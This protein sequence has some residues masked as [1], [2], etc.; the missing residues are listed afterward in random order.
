MKRL[1][2]GSML[3]AGAA[4]VLVSVTAW[5]RPDSEQD[6]AAQ[7][8]R[9]RLLVIQS[10]CGGC[11]G[12]GSDPSV[13]G[14]LA[15]PQ[16]SAGDTKIGPCAL[17]P[18][19]KPCF[20]TRPK[21]L[22]PH[23]VTGTGRYSE[24]QIFNALRYG[25][26]PD[27]TPDVEITGTTPG[28]GNYPAKPQY[29][30]PPMPWASWRHNT[31]ADLR[32]IAAYL[33][34]GLKPVDNKVADSDA[35]PDFWADAWS[36]KNAGTYPAAPYPAVSETGK[37]S[38]QIAEGRQLVLTHACGDCHGGGNNPASPNF[39]SGV[40]GPEMEWK[41]GPCSS[42]PKATPCF[43]TRPKNLTP[44]NATGTGRFTERQIFNA[45]RYGLRVEETPDVEITSTTP[46]KG[47]FPLHPHY[48]APPMPWTA[49]RHLSDDQL[50]AIAA[51]IKN[52]LKPVSNR[53]QDSD[54]PPDFWASEYTVDKIGP[55]P[56]KPFP[57][58]NEKQ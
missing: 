6:K 41:I 56:A 57:T 51:Y 29:L 54:G 28:Q 11:H 4:I 7:I 22:T 50:H 21:N 25:L 37:T 12:G 40:R 14:F 55:Y 58:A 13:A 34:N 18:N 32:A 39:L 42:D 17:D 33:K 1:V 49:W 9:G 44:D 36:D 38:A 48:L 10:D 31:D 20:I 5:K 2:S 8:A 23:P 52:G 47:N 30:A 35:P 3:A 15:G 45:L 19:A 24:R 27:K 53:V 26:K 16:G 43:I 46:G